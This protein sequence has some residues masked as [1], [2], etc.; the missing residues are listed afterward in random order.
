MEAR[1]LA[2]E[3]RLEAMRGDEDA[4]RLSLHE[5]RGLLAEVLAALQR[6]GR[7]PPPAILVTPDD[8][9][10]SVRSAI[11]LGAVVPGTLS[12]KRAAAA[13]V[14]LTGWRRTQVTCRRFHAGLVTAGLLAAILPLL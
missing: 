13:L 7:N 11:L 2:G 5:R 9:L 10:A 14:L 8:A 1:I 3:R 6:M 4:A 12:M